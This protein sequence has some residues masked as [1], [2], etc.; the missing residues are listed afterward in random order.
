MGQRS[1]KTQVGKHVCIFELE[2][3][4]DLFT[5][6]VVCTVCGVYLS[7]QEDQPP[8]TRQDRTGTSGT[9]DGSANGVLK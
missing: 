1:Y 5:T 8:G 6:E 2:R 9:S 3:K 4:G 7:S